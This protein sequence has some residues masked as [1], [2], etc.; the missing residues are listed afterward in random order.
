MSDLIPN[1]FLEFRVINRRGSDHAPN[2]T[3]S[4]NISLKNCSGYK[5]RRNLLDVWPERVFQLRGLIFQ[6]YIKKTQQ[7]RRCMRFE[8]VRL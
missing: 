8:N 7:N 5:M 4:N 3:V 6:K 1:D 2:G